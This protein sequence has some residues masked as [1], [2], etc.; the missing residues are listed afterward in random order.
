MIP[1]TNYDLPRK[2]EGKVCRRSCL[3]KIWGTQTCTP[4]LGS[5]GPTAVLKVKESSRMIPTTTKWWAVCDHKHYWDALGIRAMNTQH[6]SKPVGPT[7][8]HKVASTSH[9]PSHLQYDLRQWTLNRFK[10]QFTWFDPG[11]IETCI[12]PKQRAFLHVFQ[13][14]ESLAIS[15]PRD[16]PSR[17]KSP[18]SASR[19]LWACATSR[20]QASEALG[21][22]LWFFPLWFN[23]KEIIY[24]WAIGPLFMASKSQ[25]GNPNF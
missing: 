2:M 15:R 17:R 21:D 3:G 12:L 10:V 11:S 14:P 25:H 16:V 19:C 22:L 4:S 13:T 24:K 7:N 20:S 5:N 23:V 6:E 18:S 1:L 9:H 8:I